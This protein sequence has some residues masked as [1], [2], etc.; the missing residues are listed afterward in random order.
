M[1][2]IKVTLDVQ[3][4]RA[5]VGV[6]AEGK[7]PLVTTILCESL[8]DLVLAIPGVI[9]TAK[10]RWE[11]S[12]RNPAY[13]KP[14]AARTKTT[15]PA[16]AELTKEEPEA[17]IA[18]VDE[19]IPPP[20]PPEEPVQP[21]PLTEAVPSV[22]TDPPAQEATEAPM[23]RRPRQREGWLY[24][25]KKDSAGPF[26]TVHEV[27]LALGISQAEIDKH[28]YW[29]R[30]DRLTKELADQIDKRALAVLLAVKQEG[31]DELAVGQ[32]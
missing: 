15:E 20:L 6:G 12:A 22:Q 4:H 27:L 24:Y 9:V 18:A 2:K 25:I 32:S 5:I 10:A 29:H 28:K 13:K 26:K 1:E 30:H 3:E 8:D 14:R 16:S 11:E 31:A 19:A 21:L 17:P 7:D 23:S